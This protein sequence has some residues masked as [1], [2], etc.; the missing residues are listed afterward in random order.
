MGKAFWRSGPMMGRRV[1][2]A[3]GYRAND[4]VLP[5][6]PENESC[7]PCARQ[8]LIGGAASQLR[9]LRH[10]TPKYKQRPGKDEICM[11][12]SVVL[13]A[14]ATEWS[15]NKCPASAA[16]AASEAAS[17]SEPPSLQQSESE[18]IMTHS[19]QPN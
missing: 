11:N 7:E 19:N 2:Q 14:P 4:A 16:A 5:P 17:G 8:E 3:A 12:P 10:C 15:T 6:R 1:R 13:P 18:E 9:Q